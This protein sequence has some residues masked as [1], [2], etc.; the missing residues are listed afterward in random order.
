MTPPDATQGSWEHLWLSLQYNP[1]FLGIGG[2]WDEK[3]SAQIGELGRG[4]FELVAAVPVIGS[5]KP[6]FVL[7]FKRQ[8]A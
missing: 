1:G 5:K 2:G 3:V 8:I 6:Q 4:G 7:F